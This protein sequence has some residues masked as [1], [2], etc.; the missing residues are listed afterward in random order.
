MVFLPKC[1]LSNL[2]RYGFCGALCAH[3]KIV[4]SISGSTAPNSA[5]PSAAAAPTASTKT[6]VETTSAKTAV[7]TSSTKAT[8]RGSS[9]GHEGDRCSDN[10]CDNNFP[11]HE[12]LPDRL[13]PPQCLCRITEAYS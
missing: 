10:D 5:T 2:V 3:T 8:T 13:S 9:G 12:Y 7:E 11:E 4:P 6:A 1:N